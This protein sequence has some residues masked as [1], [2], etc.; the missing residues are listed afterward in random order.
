MLVILCS[1]IFIYLQA[2]IPL[3]HIEILIISIICLKLFE[4]NII[5]LIM[6]I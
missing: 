5:K 3:E 2:N 4:N 1:L 6:P